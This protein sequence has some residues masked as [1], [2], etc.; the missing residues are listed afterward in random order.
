MKQTRS[1][2]KA[3][4]SLD[5]HFV[6]AWQ[7]RDARLAGDARL[8]WERANLL[9]PEAREQRVNE[10]VALAYLDG[11][12]AGVATAVIAN[13]PQLRGRFAFYRCAAYPPRH[14]GERQRHER[15]AERHA[16]WAPQHTVSYA[17]SGYARGVLERWSLAHPEE[18]VLGL[19]AV[20][21]SP[22]YR[23]KQREPLW[24][25]YGLHLNLVGYTPD[26]RQIRVAW[27]EH[28][29]LDP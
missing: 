26:G 14:R 7:Q 23:R 20:I 29:R 25:D 28:A 18:K 6:D 11:K 16:V 19:A 12:V 10:L 3:A 21:E 17:L 15:P 1:D 13:L 9:T 22:G 2:T 5:L 24:P 4:P 8:L 27:F